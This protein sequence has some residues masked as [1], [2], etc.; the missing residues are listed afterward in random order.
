MYMKKTPIVFRMDYE[1]D[2]ITSTV[3]R[4]C[5]WVMAGEGVATIKFDGQ[6]ALW[7]DG[8]LWKRYDRKLTK[9]AQAQHNRG[10][11]LDASDV[12][13]FKAPPEGF[14]ACE[15]HPDPVSFHWPGWV[16]VSRDNPADKWLV[17]AM[18]HSYSGGPETFV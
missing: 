15:T 5:E 14:V 10:V 13:I 8:K 1:H 4:G 6:A 3:R 16:P 12:L 7:Q 2:Q 17:E 18:D 11:A 9:Q